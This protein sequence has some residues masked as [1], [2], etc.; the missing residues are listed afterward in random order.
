MSSLPRYASSVKIRTL[1]AVVGSKGPAPP[2]ISSSLEGTC[3]FAVKVAAAAV[4]VEAPIRARAETK[5]RVMVGYEKEKRF[6]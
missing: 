1:A 4:A 6:N 5:M 2:R 3:T